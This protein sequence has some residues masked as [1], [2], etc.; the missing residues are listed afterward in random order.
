MSDIIYQNEN[1]LVRCA[2]EDE[3]GNYEVVNAT[4]GAIEACE[5]TLPGALAVAEQMNRILRFSLWE[6]HARNMYPDPKDHKS[7]GGFEGADVFEFEP[8]GGLDS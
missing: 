1:Y 3:D 5:P 2:T 8:E 6:E 7:L 4:H